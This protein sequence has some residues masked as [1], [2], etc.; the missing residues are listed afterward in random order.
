MSEEDVAQEEVVSNTDSSEDINEELPSFTVDIKSLT[1]KVY[2]NRPL[3][4]L[5]SDDECIEQAKD[6]GKSCQ[7]DHI[8]DRQSFK[9]F[10][11]TTHYS[12]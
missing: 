11:N 12:T 2:L 6:F 8:I 7:P 10:G 5:V 9:C 3:E 4:A 1:A